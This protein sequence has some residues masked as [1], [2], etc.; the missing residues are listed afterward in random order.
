MC[1]SLLLTEC[2]RGLFVIKLRVF[3]GGV[4]VLKCV[5]GGLELRCKGNMF[6]CHWGLVGTWLNYVWQAETREKGGDMLRWGVRLVPHCWFVI[7]GI[8]DKMCIKR[9]IDLVH[10][11]ASTGPVLTGYLQ[12]VA[13]HYRA[14]CISRSVWQ[15]GLTVIID[16]GFVHYF[17]NWS[18]SVWGSSSAGH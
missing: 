11:K 17:I 13:S 18:I 12:P 5:C 6:P 3:F 4:C 2:A 9:T 1:L 14:L 16:N 10:R 7:S 8:K 15:P